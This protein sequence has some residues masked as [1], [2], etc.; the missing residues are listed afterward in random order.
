MWF[1]EFV[2]DAIGRVSPDGT[3]H[4]VMLNTPAGV[5]QPGIGA[6]P[7]KIVTGPDRNLWFANQFAPYL[8]RFSARTR[9]LTNFTLPASASGLTVG[10]DDNL[11]FTVASRNTIHRML[12]RAPFTLTSFAIPQGTG[13][14]EIITGPHD[15][16]WFLMAHDAANGSFIARLNPTSGAFAFFDYAPDQAQDYSHFSAITAGRDKRLWIAGGRANPI[17]TLKTA[18]SD[19]AIRSSLHDFDRPTPHSTPT[20]I[21]SIPR[22]SRTATR[23]VTLSGCF[24]ANAASTRARPPS[25]APPPPPLAPT[26]SPASP[27]PI[28]GAHL[29]LPAWPVERVG[30]SENHDRLA[31]AAAFFEHRCF[32]RPAWHT[33]GR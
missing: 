21:T 27:V 14:G 19:A 28:A 1:T 20:G 3:L 15:N 23:D 12:S 5:G 24:R 32:A 31:T 25:V 30:R 11:W 22:S 6:G 8:S 26:P 29:G 9:E 17:I 13:P 10:A 33:L 7:Q 4:E 16:L 2:A 18:G